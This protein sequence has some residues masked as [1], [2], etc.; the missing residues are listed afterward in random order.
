MDEE[1]KKEKR[2]ELLINFIIWL[3]R[4]YNI[5]RGVKAARELKDLLGM[6]EW[7]IDWGKFPDE[8]QEFFQEYERTPWG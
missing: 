6:S 7:V 2:I 4:Q 5:R 1:I 3:F 8:F